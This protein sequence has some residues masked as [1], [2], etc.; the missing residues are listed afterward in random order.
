MLPLPCHLLELLALFL[1]VW[2]FLCSCCLFEFL[3]QRLSIRRIERDLEARR[4][5]SD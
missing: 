1:A 2:C 4:K 5:K 3:R